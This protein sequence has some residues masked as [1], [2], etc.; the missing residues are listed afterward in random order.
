MAALRLFVLFTVSFIWVL[1]VSQ[2]SIVTPRYLATSC[3]GFVVPFNFNSG[4]SPHFL[5]LTAWDFEALVDRRHLDS[6]SGNLFRLC[7]AFF[8]A[9]TVDIDVFINA[10][11]SAYKA[12]VQQ[13]HRWCT[14]NTTPVRGSFPAGFLL[15]CSSRRMTGWLLKFTIT[16]ILPRT[17]FHTVCHPFSISWLFHCQSTLQNLVCAVQLLFL[18]IT[19]FTY[20]IICEYINLNWQYFSA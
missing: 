11:S 6:Q 5:D 4:I 2:V 16:Q 19:L 9:C 12:S 13:Y 1:I 8:V 20:P 17:F 14:L 3:H 10:A 18:T 7:C 15:W